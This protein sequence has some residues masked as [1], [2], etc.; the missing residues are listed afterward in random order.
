MNRRDSGTDDRL[1]TLGD[2]I[3]AARES[4]PEGRD[5]QRAEKRERSKADGIAWRISAELVAAF[6]VCGFVGYWVDVWLNSSPWALIA[7]LLLGGGVGI[8][9][10]YVVAR[11]IS[12]AAEEEKD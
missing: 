5:R 10:V 4:G 1:G 7:G 12:Q 2:R 8:R 3:R 6:L 11:N 9:N